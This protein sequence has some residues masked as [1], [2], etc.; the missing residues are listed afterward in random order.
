MQHCTFNYPAQLSHGTWYLKLSK[1]TLELSYLLS[2]HFLFSKEFPPG[3]NLL[4]CKGG[5][6]N[7]YYGPKPL[8]K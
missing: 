6:W 5:A 2:I 7:S 8:I 1:V 3:N 4:Q